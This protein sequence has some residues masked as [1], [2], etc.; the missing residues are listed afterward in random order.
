MKKLKSVT[1][2]NITKIVLRFFGFAKLSRKNRAEKILQ[3]SGTIVKPQIKQV[4]ATIIAQKPRCKT[5][6]AQWRNCEASN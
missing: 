4:P 1:Q 2:I 6:V 3:R 5:F